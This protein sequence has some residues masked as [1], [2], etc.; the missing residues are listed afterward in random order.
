MEPVQQVAVQHLGELNMADKET[1]A[2]FICWAM[3]NYPAEK[4]LLVFSNHGLVWELDEGEYDDWES[5]HTKQGGSRDNTNGKLYLSN[6]AIQEAIDLAPSDIAIVGFDACDMN[7]LEVLYQLRNTGTKVFI[8]SQNTEDYWGWDYVTLLSALQTRQS[9]IT[10]Q[11]IGSIVCNTFMDN[12]ERYAPF[13]N[14]TQAA[15]DIGKIESLSNNISSLADAM[16]L[17]QNDKGK[18]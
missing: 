11:E 2:N 10:E 18:V 12:N 17:S 6:R 7:M 8:G 4:Y 13:C 9:D 16:R 15:I 5:S 14:S 3:D 1:L